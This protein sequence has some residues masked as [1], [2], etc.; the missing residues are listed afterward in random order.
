MLIIGFCILVA[1]NLVAGGFLFNYFLGIP[2]WLGAVIIAVLAVAYTGTGGLIADAY[3]A[4]I[5]M[6][7]V[8]VG[9]VG[10]LIWMAVYARH[11][12]RAGHGPA[13]PRAR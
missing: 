12:D 8:L 13:R 6:T 7:L 10:L 4:I 5:Q 3:T 1:G 9:A 11:L 2:Y